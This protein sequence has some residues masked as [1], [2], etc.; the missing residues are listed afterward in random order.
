MI[1]F[2]TPVSDHIDLIDPL[3]LGQD[4]G[5]YQA[6]LL[7]EVLHSLQVLASLVRPQTHLTKQDI[8]FKAPLY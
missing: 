5:V 4:L 2:E 7:Q 8:S 6:L 3:T 1:L